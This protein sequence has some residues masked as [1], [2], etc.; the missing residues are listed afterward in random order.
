MSEWCLHVTYRP[1]F[2]SSGSPFSW[3]PWGSLSRQRIQSDSSDDNDI[4][5]KSVLRRYRVAE[6]D[7]SLCRRFN[8]VLCS[9]PLMPS[10]VRPASPTYTHTRA[11]THQPGG[12]PMLTIGPGRPLMPGTCRKTITTLTA[13]S[14][15]GS[16]LLSFYRNVILT[17][18]TSP[19]SPFWP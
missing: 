8:V 13:C 4:H 3:R 11:H 17:T 1:S 6:K 19:G 16:V 2:V 14:Q 12:R 5:H 10:S 18:G 7:V 15:T 9:C